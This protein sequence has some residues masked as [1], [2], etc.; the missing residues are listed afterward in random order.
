MTKT[1]VLAIVLLAATAA[2][3]PDPRAVAAY[4]EGKQLFTTGQFVDAAARFEAAYAIEPDPV[5]LYNIA[6]AYREGKVCAKAVTYYREFLRVV[7]DPPDPDQVRADLRE[8]EVCAARQEPVKQ[9][10]AQPV[11]ETSVLG[12]PAPRRMTT[13]RKIGIGTMAAGGATLVAGI[14]LGRAAAALEEERSALC[15]HCTWTPSLAERARDLDRRGARDA[16][17]ANV[18]YA[19][20]GAA[21]AAG[22]VMFVF[23]RSRPEAK[24]N[25]AVRIDAG[26]GGFGV[27][28]ETDL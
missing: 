24:S 6:Q 23:G 21:L 2:A 18:C 9:D 27:V 28:L 4:Q 3:D 15:D 13:L 19:I 8:A 1:L 25:P 10:P 17:Y 14:F 16:R 5:Y 26:A 11:P 7:P 12:T 20:G 22:V